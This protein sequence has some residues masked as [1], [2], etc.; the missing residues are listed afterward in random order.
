MKKQIFKIIGL[1]FIVLICF[2]VHADDKGNASFLNWLFEEDEKKEN[3]STSYDYF[4][5]SNENGIDDKMEK[6][7]IQK[8]DSKSRAQDDEPDFR[9]LESV[10]EAKQGKSIAA[11]SPSKNVMSVSSDVEGV[12][13]K[14]KKSEKASSEKADSFSKKSK[15]KK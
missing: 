13:P 2:P 14:Q 4:Q 1:T 3:S 7:P 5:D 8:S 9:M 11:P 6:N 15:R 12:A 10:S